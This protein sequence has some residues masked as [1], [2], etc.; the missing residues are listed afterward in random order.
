MKLGIIGF[1]ACGKTSLFN[2]VTGGLQPVGQYSGSPGST[3][4][5]MKVPDPRMFKMREMYKPKSFVLAAVDCVD[6][7][8]LI[9]GTGGSGG[10]EVKGEILGKLREVDGIVHVVR[11][12]ESSEVPHVLES[13][14]PMRDLGET[15]SELLFADLAQCT[16]RVEKLRVQATKPT[17]TQEQDKKELATLEKVLKLLED[18][19][20]VSTYT[21]ASDDEKRHIAAFQF[22][23]SKKQAVVFNVAEGDL[24]PGGKAEELTKKV[25]GSIA[26]C[27]KIEME[28]A[29]LPEAERA[30]FLQSLGIAEPASARLARQAYGALDAI[31]FFTV[32]EDECRAWTIHRGDNAQAAAGKIHTDLAKGFVRAEV[33][34]YDELIAAGDEKALK[35]A[36]KFRLE[37]KEYIVK[38]GDIVHIRA[39]TR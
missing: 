27:A 11:A 33:F 37:G 31:P 17:K 14:D 9:S 39:N 3:L 2:A 29:Q 5:V 16:S 7:T 36:G 12:Y 10:K 38:D 8:G 35:A 24:G 28:I 30:E 18:G 25:P 13:V 20:A 26:L 15:D 32:G 4:G 22:L 34:A 1:P 19:K 6:F 23:S 21:P